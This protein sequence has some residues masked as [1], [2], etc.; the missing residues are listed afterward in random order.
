VVIVGDAKKNK[1]VPRKIFE[2]TSNIVKKGLYKDEQEVLQWILHNQ[3]EQKINYYNKKIAEMKQK[4]DMDFSAFESR[5]CLGAGEEDFEERDDFTLW[6]GY[7]I[8]YRYWE[9]YL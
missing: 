1:R 8:A 3:A 2:P 5:I 9:Q 6:E 4:Y 7:I